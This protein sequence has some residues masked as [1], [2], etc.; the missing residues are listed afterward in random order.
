M[1]HLNLFQVLGKHCPKLLKKVSH[2]TLLGRFVTFLFVCLFRV[3]FVF[4]YLLLTL[5]LSIPC[6]LKFFQ[7]LTSLCDLRGTHQ[8]PYTN[9][10]DRAVGMA[11]QKMGP[12]YKRK[13]LSNQE[14]DLF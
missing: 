3:F 4:L 10:L 1:Y 7:L 9:K 13:L 2:A 12:R 14:L 5:G 6:I 8:F 11:I